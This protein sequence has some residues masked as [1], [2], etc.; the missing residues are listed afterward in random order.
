M[1]SRAF[2]RLGMTRVM[3]DMTFAPGNVFTDMATMP[4]G[5]LH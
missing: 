1:R 3:H 4:R 2:G 5:V